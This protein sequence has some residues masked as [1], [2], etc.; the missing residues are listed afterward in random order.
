MSYVP[1]PISFEDPLPEEIRSCMDWIGEQIH[2][3]WAANRMR[4]GWEYGPQYDGENKKHPCLIP[5]D[6]LPDSEKEYDRSTA[7]QTIQL[8]LHA[9]FQ[10]IP[11]SGESFL[12][13]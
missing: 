8:L 10:I 11:P 12:K 7:R 2:E 13:L 5:Y 4:E 3:Q 9:G 1:A 6:C